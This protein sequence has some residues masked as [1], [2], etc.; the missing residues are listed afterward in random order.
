MLAR[1]SLETC[2]A[3]ADVDVAAAAARRALSTLEVHGVAD[4][5]GAGIAHVALGYALARGSELEEA[6]K[7]LDR[8]VANLRAR[9]QPLE[10]ADA[11]LVSAPVRRALEAPLP[12]ERCSRKRGESL[13]AAR[14]QES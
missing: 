3:D 5:P 14:I 4:K 1:I 9:G 11:L 10:I 12:R 2:E 7:L 8:G 13:R 6:G